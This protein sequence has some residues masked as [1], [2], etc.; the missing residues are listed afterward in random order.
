MDAHVAAAE[1]IESK[2]KNRKIDAK[3]DEFFNDMLWS[4]S[5]LAINKKKPL[6]T[7]DQL[8]KETGKLK[9][10]IGAVDV[11]KEMKKSVFTPGIEKELGL[12]NYDVSVK[13]LRKLRKVNLFVLLC[14]YIYKSLI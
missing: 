4:Q 2:L 13:K 6:F 12:P 10:N 1:A 3:Y 7:F 14:T 11:N 8:D 5:L 9:S